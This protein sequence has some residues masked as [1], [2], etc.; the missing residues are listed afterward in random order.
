[1]EQLKTE[2]LMIGKG[3][4]D[5]GTTEQQTRWIDKFFEGLKYSLTEQGINSFSAEQLRPA[6]VAFIQGYSEGLSLADSLEQVIYLFHP[7]GTSRP[8]IK[9]ALPDSPN[10]VSIFKKNA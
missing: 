2:L 9:Q 3:L 1:V 6:Y 7:L 10:V 8:I 5:I 4:G